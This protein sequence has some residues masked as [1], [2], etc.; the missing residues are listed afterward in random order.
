M[1]RAAV[2]AIALTCRDKVIKVFEQSLNLFNLLVQSP[3]IER[4]VTSQFI[5]LLRSEQ[6]V[7]KLLTHSETSSTKIA[8]KIHEALLDLSYLPQI[9]EDLVV[10]EVYI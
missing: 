1:L 7:K 4:Q 2:V 10:K 5:G 3:K 9:G 6:V 8:S